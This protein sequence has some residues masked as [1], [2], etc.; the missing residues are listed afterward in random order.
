MAH[1]EELFKQSVTASDAADYST[2]SAVFF[3]PTMFSAAYHLPL[4]STLPAYWSINLGL[5]SYWSRDTILRSTIMHEPYWSVAVGIAASKAA[6]QSFEVKGSRSGRWQEMLVDWGGDGYVPSQMRGVID[7]C[8]T[9][10]GEFWEVVRV[11]NARGSRVL[12][13]VH[14]DSLRSVRTGDPERPVAFMDLRG[15]YHILRD[16]QVISLVDMPDPSIASMGIG[17]CAGERIYEKVYETAA[18]NQYYREKVTGSGATDLHVIQGMPTGQIESIIEIAR[19]QAVGKG[20]VYYQGAII[21]G[22]IS[23]AQLGKVSIPLRSVPDGFDREKEL[24]LAQLAYASAIGLDP[25]E[26]NPALVGHGALGIG[27]QSVVLAEKQNARGLAARDKQMTHLLNTRVLPASVTFALAERDLRDEAQRADIESVRAATR[28]AQIA[29]GEISLPQSQQ[30]AVDAGDLPREFLT[31]E[32]QTED[33]ALMDEEKPVEGQV[34]E[35]VSQPLPLVSVQPNRVAAEKEAAHTGAMIAFMLDTSDAR[36]LLSALPPDIAPVGDDVHL[37]LVFLGDTTKD[38]SAGDQLAI[39]RALQ[40]L[41]LDEPVSGVTGGIGLFIGSDGDTSALYASY[42]APAL[43]RFRERLITMLAA[44]G[45]TVDG[46]HGFTPHITLAYISSDSTIPP[47]DVPAVQLAFNKISLVWA[48]KRTDFP[49]VVSAGK[50]TSDMLDMAW[51]ILQ[52]ARREGV[53][54]QPRVDELQA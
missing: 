13:L 52:Q 29:S 34:G 3:I 44:E 33:T 8:T 26:L 48:G 32:D 54:D 2:G 30:L 1:L 15:N 24:M 38:L 22:I 5:V 21:A 16:D 28:A 42:D 47:V 17:H 7:Y 18:I 45:V 4:P 23:Q 46:K 40:A 9:N 35:T 19:N 50:P 25:Q 31:T 36:A 11:S 37:T 51:R 39:V 43:P 14:L 27:A 49:F 6:S 41:T 10:N 20:L 53:T 12:G